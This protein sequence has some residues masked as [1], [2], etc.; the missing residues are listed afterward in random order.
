MGLGKSTARRA[1]NIVIIGL[2]L[3]GLYAIAGFFILPPYAKRVAQETL[4]SRLGRTV[5]IGSVSLNPFTLVAVVRGF[6]IKEQDG[7]TA[8]LSFG[9]LTVDLQLASIIRKG[10][11]IREV[12]LEKP[13]VNLVRLSG[14]AY[15]FSDIIDRLKSGETGTSPKPG[16]AQLFSVNNIQIADGDIEFD[17][18]PG[19]TIHRITQ[20]NLAIPFIS[21]LPSYIE[22]F[23]QPSFSALVNG[24]PVSVRGNSKV[25]SDSLETSLD[26][27][28]KDL[29]IPYY[30]A[31]APPLLRVTVPSGLLDIS[32]TATYRQY[33]DRA[34]LLSLKGETRVRDVRVAVRGFPGDF[35]RIPL[36]N[37]RDLSFDMEKKRIEIGSLTT[38][39]GLVAVSRAAD[40]RINVAS[41]A[42]GP[43]AEAQP[44]AA[45]PPSDAAPWTVQLNV[46]D[47]EDYA[48]KVSDLSLAEPFQLAVDK[49]GCKVDNLSTAENAKAEIAMSL[50]VGR[51]GAVSADGGLSVN[52][53]GAD[54]AVRIKDL[55]LKPIQPFLA[56]RVKV[57][58]ASGALNVNGKVGALRADDGKL[59]TSFTGMLSVNGF[60]LL[61]AAGEE[62]LA[63]WD[64]LTFDGM[65]I[66]SEPLFVHIREITLSNF[67]ANIIVNPDRTINLGQLVSAP[68]ATPEPA[69][70]AEKNADESSDK[71]QTGPGSIRIDTITLRGGSVAFEDN[72]ITPRFNADLSDINGHVSGVSSEASTPGDV[73]VKGLYSGSAPLEITGKV[74]PF[75]ENLFV[76]LHA[77]F[78]DM[79]LPPL[80]PYSG[81]YAGYTIEKGKLSFRLDY[82]IRKNTLD[83]MNSVFLDQFSFGERVESPDATKLPVRLA[84]ALLKD[85]KGQ[86]NLDI[87]VSGELNDPKFSVGGVVLKVIVNLLVKAATSPFALIG[88]LVGGGEQLDYVEFDPGSAVLNEGNK[89]KLDLLVKALSERPALSMDI[90]GYVDPD[91][92]REGLRQALL[93]RKVKAQ[94]LKELEETGHELTDLEAVNVTPEEYPRF[95][96]QAYKKEKFPKPRN[97]IG[98]AKDLPVPEMESLMLAN[99]KVGDD[100]L[101]E[102]ADRRV[103]AVRDYL[104]RSQKLD[105]GRIFLVEAKTL[106]REKKEGA[107]DSRVDF[108]LK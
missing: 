3:V 80:S 76:D 37:V 46:L 41:I 97:F 38:K 45:S 51:K 60:S 99:L 28:L 24:T 19:K 17:D 43:R 63:A 57:I 82:R 103:R 79:D 8:F 100:D 39:K 35:V 6:E 49:I 34:P 67:S 48:V 40:G 72:S 50:R 83:A 92:D 85:Y 53:P 69:G 31:Y 15:N 104:L 70:T 94:K 30:L 77:D 55:A 87:P 73:V 27:E 1:R 95:L 68:A 65:D 66:R 56:E 61:D 11:V 5:T 20:I 36:L 2:V 98:M 4:S 64:S 86:I 52:P 102:L 84:V 9:G 74:Y 26:V 88:A 23:V 89:K 58:L 93:L 18:R 90:V 33:A 54:L 101:K 91:K 32:L 75:R 13:H 29:N 107:K 44:E 106:S 22:S 47:I 78:K 62:D 10:P 7:R 59:T 105:P 21:N 16:K 12:R 108:K 81:R 71:S 25:F 42:A 14:D 96:K